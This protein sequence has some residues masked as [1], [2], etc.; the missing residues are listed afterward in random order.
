MPGKAD[1]SMLWALGF[2]MGLA[3]DLGQAVLGW[4]PD[5]SVW[6]ITDGGIQYDSGDLSSPREGR[7]RTRD[8][9]ENFEIRILTISLR[10][11]MSMKA[12][13]PKSTTS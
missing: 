7:N 9:S 4:G 12:P 10:N 3:S 13:D 6:G 2:S 1:A 11:R 8:F 5:Q